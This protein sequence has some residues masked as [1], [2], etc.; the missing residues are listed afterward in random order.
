MSFLILDMETRI[1]KTL[2]RV[3]Q[4]G[5]EAIDDEA[6]FNRLREELRA[7][8][9]SDFFPLTYHVPVSVVLGYADAEYVLTR[10]EDLRADALGDA[11]LAREVWQRLEAFDG[12]LVTFNGR[13]FDLPVLELSALRH[14]CVARRYFG[15][16]NGLRSRYGRHLDLFDFLTNSGATRLRGGLDLVARLVGLPGKAG[17]RGGDVQ[18][19]WEAGRFDEIHRYCRR[20]VIETYLVFLHVEHLRGRLGDAALQRAAAAAAPFRAELE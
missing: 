19:L 12:T 2:V 16:R 3:T 9:G 11:A 13:G 18:A 1:D 15:E 7:Q 4:F 14:G 8:S 17:V 6:A 10:L 20:D 5:G